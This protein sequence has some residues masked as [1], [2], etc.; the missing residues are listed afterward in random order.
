MALSLLQAP[1]SAI[2]GLFSGLKSVLGATQLTA[3]INDINNVQDITN[4]LNHGWVQGEM[5]LMSNLYFLQPNI[6]NGNFIP[7]QMIKGFQLPDR[8]ITTNSVNFRGV[9]IKYPAGSATGDFT[10]TFYER[11]D[12]I[13]TG[14]YEAW[15]SYAASP[16]GDFY[17]L[18]NN[19]K[20]DMMCLF[21]Q[22][23][24]GGNT[25]SLTGQLINSLPT[26]TANA[27]TEYT[28]AGIALMMGCF[29]KS[30]SY[31]TME[32][33]VDGKVS[34]VEVQVTFSCDVCLKMPLSLNLDQI[35]EILGI[36]RQGTLSVV[37]I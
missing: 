12:L 34:A 22:S 7:Q 29:P 27:I 5:P 8:T 31:P 24:G 3:L 10:V 32:N 30:V 33:P 9:N 36:S 4:Y 13:V 19:T 2:S 11:Q 35:L 23:I 20:F 26:G 21:Q 6:R 25:A 15:K 17:G 14:F 1:A 18:P 37:T 28:P 16:S